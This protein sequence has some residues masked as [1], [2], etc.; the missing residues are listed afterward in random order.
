L[1]FLGGTSR[2]TGEPLAQVYHNSVYRLASI[3]G[4][5]LFQGRQDVTRACVLVL[6]GSD[7]LDETGP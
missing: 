4:D 3:S 5:H 2:K 7:T 1:P 6:M